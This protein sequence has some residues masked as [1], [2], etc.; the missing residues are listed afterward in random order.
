MKVVLFNAGL[1]NQIFTYLFCRYLQRHFPNDKI[2]G[3]Y[4]MGGLQ[5]HE[6]LE[7]DKVF[8]I[9]LPPNTFLTDICSKLYIGLTKLGLRQFLEKHEFARWN[10]VFD[11]QW[12]DQ[13]YFKELSLKDE[14]SFRE[15]NI[16]ARN[17][18]LAAVI[19]K[20]ESVA[21]HIRRGDYLSKENWNNFGRFCTLDYYHDSISYIKS[22]ISQPK[23]YFFS[24][25]IDYAKKEFASE[26]AVFVD[27]NKGK[28][29]WKDMFLMSKCKHQIIANST[30]S[31]WA[32]QL[33]TNNDNHIVIA[34]KKWYIWEDPDIFP[35]EWLR[36]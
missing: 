33:A 31:Y 29:S 7:V 27:F 20:E 16:D 23:F 18:A 15:E 9:K 10:F 32:A 26:N 22:T 13:K 30:F 24:D 35:K 25:D 8:D 12:L 14:L 36:M 4:W 6:G 34:P 1:G 2:Y 5:V 21:V 11:F 28:E 3:S 17:M 19:R